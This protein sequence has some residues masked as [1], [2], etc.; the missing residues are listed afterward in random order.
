MKTET[1]SVQL[2]FG[3]ILWVGR[4]FGKNAFPFLFPSDHQPDLA[5]MAEEIN[6][7]RET[8]LQKGWIKRNADNTYTV[9]RLIYFLV[10]WLSQPEKV[11]VVDT[12]SNSTEATHL[13]IHEKANHFLFVDFNQ[14]GIRLSLFK[15]WRSLLDHLT[16]LLPASSKTT[17]HS[18]SK[19]FPILQPIE[20]IRLTWKSVPMARESLLAAGFQPDKADEY[21]NSIQKIQTAGMISLFN[22]EVN[23]SEP[24]KQGLFIFDVEG[25]W[26]GE[27][28][29][30][31][32]MVVVMQPIDRSK[33]IDRFW[34]QN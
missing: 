7:G 11:A 22:Y 28:N 21:L 25:D 32:E 4:I 23:E 27:C 15:D 29:G 31:D 34:K 18:K 20:L 17:G 9:D 30:T 8:L 3:E 16:E 10:D 6:H 1:F 19:V 24:H 14:D 5:G 33:I 13:L 26:L 2:S 12:I